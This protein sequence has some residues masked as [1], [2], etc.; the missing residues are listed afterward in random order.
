MVTLD[1]F[2]RE[3]CRNDTAFQ[4][5]LVGEL[6]LRYSEVMALP[7]DDLVLDVAG[8]YGL[9]FGGT[10]SPD[11][12]LSLERLFPLKGSSIRVGLTS[13]PDRTGPGQLNELSFVYSVDLVRNAFGRSTALLR[14]IVGIETEAA[15]SRTVLG[16]ARELGIQIP[17]LC[18]H[19]SLPPYGSCRICVVEA[20]WKGRS[21]LH[22]ACT[23]PAW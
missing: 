3:S 15:P 12:E 4:Q 11:L 9:T 1:E 2:I 20:I 19:P 17:T 23:F 13:A 18:S 7:V 6:R 8:E 10:S 14:D 5:I 16:V 21:K 22:T